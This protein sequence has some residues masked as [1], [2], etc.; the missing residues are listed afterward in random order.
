MI[1]VR[2]VF[3]T[4]LALAAVCITPAAEAAPRR[5][6]TAE[7][8][9]KFSDMGG[10]YAVLRD[11]GKDTGCMITFDEHTR[12][13]GGNR[14]ALAPAC[15]DQGIVVFDPIAWHIAGSKL[16]LTA[17]KGHTAEFQLQP[18]GAWQKEGEGKALGLKKF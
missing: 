17:R 8:T 4:A 10:R 16:I 11:N 3:F 13:A 14:A 15:R 5:N 12:V 18:G 7:P 9:P 1:G 2:A 6:E